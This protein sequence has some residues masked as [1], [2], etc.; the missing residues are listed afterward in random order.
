MCWGRPKLFLGKPGKG[1][2][3]LRRTA[4]HTL[5]NTA[6]CYLEPTQAD[7]RKSTKHERR[8]GQKNLRRKTLGTKKYYGK[9]RTYSENQLHPCIALLAL[10]SVLAARGLAGE[11]RHTISGRT[12]CVLHESTA[13]LTERNINNTAGTRTRAPRVRKSS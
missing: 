3:S 13:P 8:Q 11:S 1:S 5:N 7:T 10:S 2:G 9:S 6:P 12:K 4:I